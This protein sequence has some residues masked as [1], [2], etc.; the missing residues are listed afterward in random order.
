MMENHTIC[1]EI[2]DQQHP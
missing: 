1:N 2:E